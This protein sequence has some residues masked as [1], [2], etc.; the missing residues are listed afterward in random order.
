MP[1][2]LH[3]AATLSL[4]LGCSQPMA[5]VAD[6]GLPFQADPPTVYVAKVKDILVGL[7]PTDDEIAAVTADPNALKGLVDQWMT[8][9]E[10]QA[11]MQV[12]FELAF[13]QTQITS[14][15]FTE[16]I[17][18]TGLGVGAQI[19]YLL[20]NIRE[21]FA[22]TV[23][24]LV[25]AGQPITEAFHTRQLMM[26]PALMELYAFLDTRTVDD[27][28]AIADSFDAANQTLSIYLE[29]AQGPIPITD[30]LNPSSP[31]YMHFYDPDV[32]KLTNYADQTCNVDP[33]VLTSALTGKNLSYAM[34]FLLYG[35]VVNHKTAAG[36]GCPNYATTGF[37]MQPTDFS[38]WKM[39]TLRA[40]KTGEAPTTFYDLPS[41][42]A[43]NE[44]VMKT[45]RLGFFT[46]PAFNANWPT[47]T[48][49]QMRVTINQTLIVTTGMAIDG[50]DATIPSSTPGLDS[51]H[52]DPGSPCYSCHQLLDPTRSILSST[53]SWYYYPQ[54]DVALKAQKGLFAFQ[55]VVKPVSS[56]DDFAQV[57]VDHPAVPQAWAQ[58][59][60]YWVN[61][62][63]CANDD[64]EFQ[65]IVAAFQGSNLSWNT[66]VRELLSS[67]I[68]TN[69]AL[70]ETTTLNG[71]VIAVDRRDHLCAA[72]D[73]RLGLPD[74][75]GLDLLTKRPTSAVP[76]IVGGLPSDGYGRGATIPVL[77]NQPT[78]F[79]RAGLENI[80]ESVA[81]L[82]IDA[83]ANP[84][85]PNV[86]MWSSAQ[87]DAAIA[88]FVSQI[89]ALT[90][91]DPRAA[92]AAALLKSHFNDAMTSGASAS[93][94]LKSTFITACL[95]P[96]SAGIGL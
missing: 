60:C 13:Q 46:T 87:P 51:M 56:I 7:P 23:L 2:I 69:T 33:I 94:A 19:P 76:Q 3:I 42:R 47:N 65:R 29:A 75:C 27:K 16:M 50:T 67:P 39:V 70:T 20:Q 83:K 34:H 85:A 26:T 5:T 90:S 49:N 41:L 74:I 62:S 80:C 17:P 9:P 25:N 1:R 79:Y 36:A 66:L 57:L 8:M 52:S 37:Q 93:D 81:P 4:A 72:L 38:T 22:R 18:P 12:F 61:S 45:P 82:V 14:A 53:F 44:L 35:G 21:S 32:G 88:D 55:G 24:A 91:K 64:P 89:M 73:N 28:A 58:K 63:P 10:Y 77:P 30:S 59:L 15:D 84:A 54:T 40:P 43:A 48:S 68:T 96:S 95:A 31:S 71:E 11:K 6:G 86:K 92:Q 78:L